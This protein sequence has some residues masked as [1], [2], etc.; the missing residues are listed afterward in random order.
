MFLYVFVFL[1]LENFEFK[2][3]GI[4][5]RKI[6]KTYLCFHTGAWPAFR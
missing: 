3:N 4:V 5:A 1:F 2:S 6:E